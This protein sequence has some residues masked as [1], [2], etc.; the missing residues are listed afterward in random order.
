M[1]ITCLKDNGIRVPY[2]AN[3]L[4]PVQRVNADREGSIVFDDL[5][6]A[7][8]QRWMG[9]ERNIAV[10]F[11]PLRWSYTLP[12]REVN[13]LDCSTEELAAAMLGIPDAI[14]L[15]DMPFIWGRPCFASEAVPEN[16]IWVV[17]EPGYFNGYE[18]VPTID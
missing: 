11:N 7:I 4:S 14:D 1:S 18:V 2:G 12:P 8:L 3:I 5:R 10:V 6:N 17:G 15:T 13:I 9:H 16:E